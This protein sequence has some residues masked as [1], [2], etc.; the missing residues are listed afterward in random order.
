M[1]ITL[2]DFNKIW[3][4]TSPLSPYTFSDDDYNDGWNFIGQI[5]PSRQMWDFL[6]KNND[7]KMQYLA[8]NY[9][10][11]SGGT[12]TGNLTFNVASGT[13]K[14]YD[15][16]G[17]TQIF[18]S[19]AF[20]KG[21]F[22]AIYGKDHSTDSG[23]FK[24]VAHDGT[25]NKY[26]EGRPDGKLTWDGNNVLTDATVGTRVSNSTS[27]TVNVSSTTKITS[28]NLTAGVWV[29]TGQLRYQQIVIGRLGVALLYSTEGNISMDKDGVQAHYSASAS[30]SPLSLSVTRIV[31]SNSAMTIY[32]DA[33]SDY[34]SI[35]TDSHI[36]A[37]RIV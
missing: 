28:I 1:A 29:V 34:T 13:I 7:E 25:N 24:L 16:S 23:R 27:E 22:L 4:S 12:M 21:A 15:D 30:S 26:L 20:N 36:V 6:Q 14:K 10:P 37:V 2:A 17:L 35:V 32:L 11:L 8:N 3:S 5:P 33:Y 9:L 31:N 19:T 18:S